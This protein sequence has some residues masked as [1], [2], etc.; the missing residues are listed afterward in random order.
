MIRKIFFLILSLIF[1]L[2]VNIYLRSFPIFFPQLKSQARRIVEESIRQAITQQVYRQFPQYYSLAKD[3]IIRQRFL[4]YKKQNKQNIKRQIRDLYLKLKDRYQDPSG[5]TYLMELDCWHWARYVENV[6]KFGHPGDEVIFGRQWDAFMLAPFGSFLQW[7]AFLYYLSAFCYKV[8]SLF[9]SV[10][11]FHFLFYLPLFYITLFIVALYGFSFF[12]GGYIAA[13]ISCLFI[14]L[15]SIFLPRSC[16]GWFD[17]DILNLFFPLL[18]MW[19]YI[20]SYLATTLKRRIFWVIIS[21]FLV[22]LFCFTWTHWWFIVMIIIIYEF[23]NLGYL[24]F[25]HSFLKKKNFTLLKQHLFFLFS[26]VTLSIFW[27]LILAGTQPLTILYDQ[28]AE[29]VILNI[30]LKPSIWPNVYYTVGELR[31]VPF[32]DMIRSLGGR[33]LFGLSVISMLILLI[34]ALFMKAYSTFKRLSILILFIWFVSMLFASLRGVR[35]TVFLLMPLGIFLGCGISELYAYVKKKRIIFGIILVGAIFILV[36]IICINRGYISARGIFPLMDDTWY[37]VLNIIKEKTSAETI[38]NSWWDFGDW[39]KVV[40]RRRVIFDG[41]SQM[42]PQVYWMAKALLTNNEM[43][44]IHILMM[45]NNSGNKAFETINKY[46]NDPLQSVLLLEYILSL[47]PDRGQEVLKKFLP[48]K[49]TFEVMKMIYSRPARAVFLVDHTLPLKIGAISYLGNWDFSKVYVAQNFIKKEKDRII[50]Y[51]REL[52]RD[53]AEINRFYQEVFLISNKNLD[54]WLSQRY[55]FYSGI[56]NGREEDGMIIFDNGFVYDPKEKTIKS[57]SGQIPRSLFTLDENDN[58]IEKILPNGNV[59]FSILV[60]KSENGYKSVL[61]DRALGASV[62]VRLY[63]LNG[64]GLRYFIPFINT[65]E[66]NNYIR[67]FHIGW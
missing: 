63:F 58:L 36:C 52:G 29:A 28:V 6:V 42:T 45:L 19:T 32:E 5:Q 59:I 53:P 41:Q 64:K 24:L 67:V 20:L 56:S 1:V 26:F 2:G 35:F 14:G 60:F 22:G 54:D 7:E 31:K 18:I 62:F 16:A 39:F 49:L 37:K 51:L 21:T 9:K 30:P 34:R 3:K 61:L 33:W 57:N 12:C 55:M 50:D 47:T 44:A 23:M 46:I 11:L 38:I 48:E 25:S 15:A 10:S 4:E 65:E 66:G 13:I 27:I 40:S 43:E 8:F 17:T